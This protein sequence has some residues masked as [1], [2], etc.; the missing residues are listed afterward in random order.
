[1]EGFRALMKENPISYIDS[2]KDPGYLLIMA[3]MAV[4][5]IVIGLQASSNDSLLKEY[6]IEKNLSTA[7][8]NK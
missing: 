5:S 6:E 4:L 7:A 1:M 2:F 3:L 8:A